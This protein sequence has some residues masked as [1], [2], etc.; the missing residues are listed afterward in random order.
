MADEECFDLGV[1]YDCFLL[2]GAGFY[3]LSD[4]LLGE[5]LRFYSVVFH[6]YCK[7]NA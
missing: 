4:K 6:N 7:T 3:Y 2:K 5:K 1:A